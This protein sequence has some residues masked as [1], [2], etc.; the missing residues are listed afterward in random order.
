QFAGQAEDLAVESVRAGHR[1]VAAAGGDGTV[2]EVANGILRAAHPDVVFTLFP[3]GSA[4]DYAHS[5][6][7]SWTQS[8]AAPE[9]PTVRQ[10]DA[11]MAQLTDGRRRFFVN[12]LGLGFSGAVTVESRNIR[13]LR[14]LF[15]YGLA[16]LRAWRRRYSLP[17]TTIRI[18]GQARRERTLSLT[19]A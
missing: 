6:G 2:H 4:N 16:F 17:M 19:I 5:L 8:L 11:G 10:V 3:I 9:S 7:L 18:D 12:S 13:R 14:G 1:L 15:L